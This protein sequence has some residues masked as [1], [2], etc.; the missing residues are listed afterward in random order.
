MAR[1]FIGATPGA[2]FSQVRLSDVYAACPSLRKRV[3]SFGGLGKLWVA[4]HSFLG[5]CELGAKN[6]ESVWQRAGIAARFPSN[7]VQS[8]K[9]VMIYAWMPGFFCPP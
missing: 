2:G 9:E 6:P 7:C 8:S 5:P 1:K 3:A 4:S